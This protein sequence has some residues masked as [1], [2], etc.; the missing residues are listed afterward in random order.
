MTKRSIVTQSG[1]TTT[2][3]IDIGVHS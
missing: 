1:Y 3:A 2:D